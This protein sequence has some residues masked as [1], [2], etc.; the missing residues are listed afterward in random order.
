MWLRPLLTLNL[1]THT[2]IGSTISV[3]AILATISVHIELTLNLLTHTDIDYTTCI[4][5]ISATTI[6]HI[7]FTKVYEHWFHYLVVVAYKTITDSSVLAT[8]VVH[9]QS[10]LWHTDINPTTCSRFRATIIVH[11]LSFQNAYELQS[12]NSRCCLNS[13]YLVSNQ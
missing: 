2:V 9:T 8:I 3:V 1:L 10:L 6:V 7:E 11:T 12:H 5:A 4:V 13:K